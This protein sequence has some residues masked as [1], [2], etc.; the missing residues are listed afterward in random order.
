M[1]DS[2]KNR[3]ISGMENMYFN[4]IN[5][6]PLEVYKTI[7]DKDRYKHTPNMPLFDEYSSYIN[8]TLVK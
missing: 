4:A 1:V 8:T 3:I 5:N 6:L 2:E 7:C